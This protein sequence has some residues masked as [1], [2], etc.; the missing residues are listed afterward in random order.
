M[1]LKCDDVV[2]GL[3]CSFVA[4]GDNPRAVKDAMMAHGAAT[5]SD[6][7]EGMS[8]EEAEAAAAQMGRHIEQLIA[9]G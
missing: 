5:H 8:P 4:T 1:E 2:P 7:M 6:L 9:G 3:S